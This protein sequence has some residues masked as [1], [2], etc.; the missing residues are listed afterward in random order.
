MGKMKG[1][2]SG[3]EHRM[4]QAAAWRDFLASAAKSRIYVDPDID[5]SAL[6]D[7]VNEPPEGVLD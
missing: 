1:S 5:I 6:C 2:D 3:Y 4:A 7:E